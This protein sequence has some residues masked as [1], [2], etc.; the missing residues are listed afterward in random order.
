[1]DSNL[2]KFNL[3]IMSGN[4]VWDE[5]LELMSTTNDDLILKYVD[6]LSRIRSITSTSDPEVVEASVRMLGVNLARDLLVLNFD[7][8]TQVFDSLPDYHLVAGT[9]DWPKYV[10][11]LLGHQFNS[12]LLYTSDYQTFVDRPLGSMIT[13]GGNWY[14]STHAEV[15][16]DSELLEAGIDLRIMPKDKDTVLELLRTVE[17]LSEEDA[18]YWYD[19]HLGVEPNN[20]DPLQRVIRIAVFMRRVEELFY[21]W[22][23]I[24]EVLH[25]IWVTTEAVVE[26][27]IGSV[28]VVEPTRYVELGVSREVVSSNFV[29]AQSVVGGD[30]ISFGFHRVWSDGY[31]ETVAAECDSEF[32]VKTDTPGLYVAKDVDFIQ[33]T[34][35]ELT[36]GT[37]AAHATVSIYPMGVQIDPKEIFILT[38]K[39]TL[40]G[41]Q[42]YT[43]QVKGLYDGR[44]AEI[45]F[46][47]G[48]LSFSTT[49]GTIDGDILTLPSLDMHTPVQ[50]GCTYTGG[51]TRKTS[52]IFDVA[53][54][55]IDL[56]PVELLLSGPTSMQQGQ[57]FTLTAK[58]RM[59]DQSLVEVFPILKSSTGRL[60]ING[61]VCSG[62]RSI[63]PYRATVSAQYQASGRLLSA[64]H[65][66]NLFPKALKVGKMRVDLPQVFEKDVV[67][68]EL[69]VLWVDESA[70]ADQIA[71]EDP[72][73]VYGWLGT[74]ASWSSIPG[75]GRYFIPNVNGTTGEFTAP[76]VD[77]NKVFAL[78]AS[79][80]VENKAL[81]YTFPVT[82]YNRV[83]RIAALDF[84]MPISIQSGSRVQIRTDALWN[85]GKRT[86]AAATYV[87]KY[88]PSASAKREARARILEEIERLAAEGKDYSHL[89]PD[90]PDYSRWVTVSV[91]D[92]G[93]KGKDSVLGVEYDIK[94]LYFAG[95]LHGSVELTATYEVLGQSISQVQKL[96]LVPIRALVNSLTI[97][98][99]D[100]CAE[101]SRSFVRALASFTDGT[102]EYVAADW[103]ADWEGSE[104][105]D[106]QLVEFVPG[107][108]TG[109]ELVK[110]LTGV[111]PAT[112]LDFEAL[113]V[114]RW[115]MFSNIGSINDLNSNTYVGAILAARK[116]GKTSTNVALRARYYRVEAKRDMMIVLSS[117][118]IIDKVVASK[119][120]GPAEFSAGDEYASYGLLNTYEIAADLS[121]TGE[122]VRYDIEVSSDWSVVKTELLVGE[123]WVETADQYV[124]ISTDGY[125]TPLLNDTVRLTIRATFD[126]NHLTSFTRDIQVVMTKANLYLAEMFLMG[127]SEVFDDVTKNPTAQ[128]LNGQWFVPYTCRVILADQSV[129]EP[130]NVEWDLQS[131]SYAESVHLDART[132]RLFVGH[133]QSD[134]AITLKAKYSATVPEDGSTETITALLEVVVKSATAVD[135]AYIEL[136]HGNIVTG[137]PVQMVMHYRRRTGYEASSLNPDATV[138][139]SW[140][141]EENE[142]EAD[143]D[144]TGK[145][146]FSVNSNAQTVVV[147]CILTEGN[148]EIVESLRVTCPGVGFPLGITMSGYANV[149]DDSSMNFVVTCARQQR[150]S[151]DVSNACLYTLVDAEGNE[152]FVRGISVDPHTGVLKADRIIKDTD[153][154]IRALYVEGDFRLMAYHSMRVY[155]SY[156]RYGAAEFG[157]NTVVEVESDLKDRL[158]SSVGGTIV[159]DVRDANFGYFCCR[160]DDGRPVFTALPDNS[161][162]VNSG[163]SGWDGA[164]WPVTGTSSESGPIE[165]TKTYDNVTD[166]WLLYRT[167][168]RGFGFAVLGVRYSS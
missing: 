94:G 104:D 84:V 32:F 74:D 140:Y 150:P 163:W 85:Y 164:R 166:K 89:D 6:E 99:Q 18:S 21:Q 36:Y 58:V 109:M 127:P 143:I 113:S 16:V 119:I 151:T 152:T 1:M 157:V 42:S 159:L 39:A 41:S 141:L 20:V 73:I 70:T 106:Y 107:E 5:L 161:G 66:V 7:R 118:G 131:P 46:S 128:Y 80:I 133:Q 136:P 111:T 40:Y 63:G 149:R 11:F 15:E 102:T 22:A 60:S 69:Q 34:L 24:E 158:N 59:S 153:I 82:V 168:R 12:R 88:V 100:Y 48:V 124:S 165:L 26:I 103:S 86:T 125:V 116:L 76:V 101:Q 81:S 156:P 97:E 138:K 33:S 43:L 144:Q 167:N 160:A 71:V 44:Y 29:Y 92:T 137:E 108:Y 50:V 4:P 37:S 56:V 110:L 142:G 134:A 31:E 8:Y 155:S 10:A 19:N 87:V 13:E 49:Q 115:Q 139:F 114:S 135:S 61:L 90:A 130:K 55:N 30:T 72:S 35:I 45:P 77:G 98:A 38:P 14:L 145:L 93:L 53:P 83:P 51:L 65:S 95:D 148:T 146:T 27:K 122:V 121:S 120:I 9:T 96:S 78:T 2:K 17:G 79:F 67:R 117:G 75:A 52:R 3:D 25:G 112:M 147:V 132:G 28:V 123:S 154:R 47:S 23:P 57:E 105:D 91:V 126:D 129:I 62:N 64:S 68:P 54:D 162:S